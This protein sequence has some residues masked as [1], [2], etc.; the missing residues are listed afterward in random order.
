MIENDRP[1]KNGK[2][3]IWI[4]AILSILVIIFLITKNK[5]SDKNITAE[6]ASDSSTIESE[7]NANWSGV[8]PQPPVA[9]YEE[10]KD[11]DV[12]IRGNDNYAV[13]SID[14]SILFD[15]ES[16]AIKPAATSKLREIATSAEKRFTGGS[17]R[18]YGYTDASGS[19]G[20]N[21]KLAEDRAKAVKNWLTTK[22]NI[23]ADK[24]SLNP[25]GESNPV[26]GN[27]TEAGRKKNRRV[28]IAVKK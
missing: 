6:A 14:E 28:E 22:N 9:E 18:I 19:K 11:S 10:L 21:K 24:I 20:Y 16:T 23:P 3:L 4:I 1:K 27:Q 8:D 17:F 13:Y 7:I 2:S 5:N 12:A 15:S 26:A 25:V